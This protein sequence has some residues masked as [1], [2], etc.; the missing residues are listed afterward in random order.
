MFEGYE[1][2]HTINQ[3]IMSLNKVKIY[4]AGSIG[5]H[6]A[7]ASRSIGAKV[8][9]VDSDP[10]ALKRMEEDIYPARYG[11]WDNEISLFHSSDEPKGGYDLI[12][13]GTPPHTHLS[14]AIE[15][16]NEKP[17]AIQVEKPLC[18]PS[19]TG[20]ANLRNAA[21]EAGIPVFVGYDHVVGKSAQ[22]AVDL[23]KEGLLGELYTIDVEFREYWGGIFKA[24][25]WLE[26]PHDSY[27]GFWE[28]GGGASGEHSHALNLWQH[29]AHEF[30]Y[31]RVSSVDS[32]IRYV[33]NEK[34]FYDDICYFNLTTE[35]GFCGRV[36]QDVV[37]NPVQKKAWIQGEKGS[38]TLA[39]NHNACG[40]AIMINR[41]GEQ[42]DII[43]IEKTR[44]D[45]FIDEL[46]HIEKYM[47]DTS[48]TSPLD[49]DR[50]L[51]TILIVAAAHS[52]HA[53]G[54]RVAIKP[55]ASYSIDDLVY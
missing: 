29:L 6:L 53:A 27:L 34:V 18:G 26:G 35:T 41:T 48:L 3:P 13:I 37:T 28:K 38:L 11:H 15:A 46:K 9:I 47:D 7:N 36:V 12:C 1:S 23:V 22:K 8:D 49:L 19:M 14:L 4:G 55:N 30:G 52:G 40:D 54:K 39:I 33:E 5:N 20:A 43:T 10:A 51:D 32:L 2:I 42:P 31:G 45:D 24:H 17:R 44:P 16:V 25:S 50:A 21:K